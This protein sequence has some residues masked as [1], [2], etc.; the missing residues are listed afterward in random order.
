MYE[1]V[2]LAHY[3][4]PGRLFFRAAFMPSSDIG[5]RV[6]YTALMIAPPLYY[7]LQYSV[8]LLVL[9]RGSRAE[10]ECSIERVLL[11]L[12]TLHR[13]SRLL[14]SWMLVY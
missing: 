14:E 9:S 5:H 11:S 10:F 4:R 13:L 12:S 7:V 2:R 6:R 1:Y 8:L 3:R